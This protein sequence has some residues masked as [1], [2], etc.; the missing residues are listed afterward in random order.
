MVNALQKKYGPENVVWPQ[1][2]SVKD[3][4]R[5]SAYAYE[6]SEEDKVNRVTDNWPPSQARVPSIFLDYTG[7]REE[8]RKRLP[9][10]LRQVLSD[11]CGNLHKFMVSANH[12]FTAVD[13]DVA[14][15]NGTEWKGLE[16]TGFY[17]LFKNRNR[18]EELVRK[19]KLRPSWQGTNGPI[20][21]YKILEAGRD[22]N[23][24][25]QM[26]Y[27]NTTGDNNKIYKVT[28]NAY[29]FSLNEEQVM[30]LRDGRTPRE[31]QFGKV[32]QF[33]STI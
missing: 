12:P 31:G 16:I 4:G 2:I 8:Q 27:M 6:Y 20:A 19:T 30:L 3:S 24:D 15:Y 25:L 22:L 14:W 9:T 23:I 11:S 32:Q 17:S 10:A 28:E 1:V 26:L 21:M 29:W 33:L 18:T 13:I 5:V 7:N